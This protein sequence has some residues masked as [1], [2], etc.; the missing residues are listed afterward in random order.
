M[1]QK[2]YNSKRI[3]LVMDVQGRDVVL[4]GTI[5]LRE[6]SKQGTMMRI[7]VNGDDDAAVGMP[8]FLISEER[9]KDSVCC[10]IMHDCEYLL[11]LS[12]TAVAAG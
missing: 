2:R 4:Q 7:T 1:N 6:D 8:V 5:S 11:D 10:G 12:Q 3:A 9:W